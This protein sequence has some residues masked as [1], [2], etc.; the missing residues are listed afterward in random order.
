MP[1]I[2]INNVYFM[3]Y[4][5]LKV[6]KWSPKYRFGSGDSLKLAGDFRDLTLTILKLNLKF[7][8]MQR[9]LAPPHT[10]KFQAF[11]FNIVGVRAGKSPASFRESPVSKLYLGLHF[12]TFKL[13]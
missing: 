5:N 12:L 13:L 6:R 10:T 1:N 7:C 4:I 3:S 8:G 11:N 2:P 9:G